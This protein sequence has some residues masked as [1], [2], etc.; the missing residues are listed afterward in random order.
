MPSD[1]LHLA[2]ALNAGTPLPPDLVSPVHAACLALADADCARQ[3]W[4]VT[5]ER[6]VSFGELRL[7]LDQVAG[8]LAARGIG[9]G[10]RL[11]FSMRD[12][13]EVALLFVALI[14]NGV[15]AIHLDPDTGPE[16]ARA[17]VAASA[18]AL[19]VLDPALHAAWWPDGTTAPPMP[20]VAWQPAP[21]G[22]LMGRLLGRSA[23]LEGLLAELA[24]QPPGTPPAAVPLETLAYILFTSGTTRQPKGVA[25]SHRALFAHLATLQQTYGYTP[26]SRILNTLMLSH[27]DGMIQGP[28]MAFFSRAT[29]HRPMRFEV[30][31]LPALLDAIWQLR[32]THMVAVPTMLA[33]MQRLGG[34][35]R[36]VF[37]G[38]DFRLLISCGAQLE[39]ALWQAVVAQFKVPLI[40]VYGLTETVVGG[41]FAGPG[42]DCG[43]PGSI[44]RPV[45]CELR[46]VDGTGQPVAAG[47]SGELLMR[48]ALLMSGYFNDDAQTAEVLRDGWFHTGDIARCDPDGH[49]RIVGRSKNVVIRGGYNIH[50]EEVTEVLQRHPAVREAV[51]FGVPDPTWGETVAALVVVEGIGSDALLAWCQQ[52]LEPRKLPSRLVC[53]AELP[54]GRSGKVMLDEA[55]RLLDRTDAEAPAAMRAGDTAA[56]RESRLRRVAGQCFRLPPE[57]I[58]LHAAPAQTPGWDSLA[59]IELV[60]ALEAEFGRTFTPREV[61]ALD[62]LDKVLALLDR[63]A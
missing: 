30:T 43:P 27:A 26:A 35:Q 36:D 54:R 40:N 3:P 8:W 42:A 24:A 34:E 39:A 53:V 20:V 56:D 14:A 32:I 22:R 63:P 55:R 58:D 12:D 60:M 45:D 9:V 4:L 21:K 2:A 23:P 11:L 49:Y 28:V 6:T 7:R 13:V 5:P 57:A 31:R 19:L 50:P 47:D 62:R 1:P 29:L 10:D 51:T 44:G 38:G 18:P 16:R 33:L 46:I 17:L 15:T 61:M 59:H 25:I 48:G 41:V 37:Q 52:H